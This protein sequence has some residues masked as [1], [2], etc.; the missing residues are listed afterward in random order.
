[1]KAQHFWGFSEEPDGHPKCIYRTRVNLPDRR[2]ASL[3]R[4]VLS[5]PG[6]P[7]SLNASPFGG[8]MPLSCETCGLH[9]RCPTP[10]WQV[11]AAC[12]AQGTP[13]TARA[14]L[15]DAVQAAAYLSFRLTAA[16]GL[17]WSPP[18]WC[19]AL[20]RLSQ[21]LESSLA[22]ASQPVVTWL[23]PVC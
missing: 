14:L 19:K 6:G 10:T 3:V 21:L 17:S 7:S 18:G 2:A 8:D 11:A 15:S 5:A 16:R 23:W 13:P 4:T 9:S 12:L 22:P 1:M 20:T